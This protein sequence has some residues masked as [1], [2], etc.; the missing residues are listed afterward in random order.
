MK[1]RDT[2][3]YVQLP[4]TL[5]YRLLDFDYPVYIPRQYR[6]FLI[7]RSW[8]AEETDRSFDGPI[9]LWRGFEED[10]LE[11]YKVVS[12]PVVFLDSYSGL[13][14]NP[15]DECPKEKV[16]A[17]GPIGIACP[18]YRPKILGG[19]EY[20]IP[21]VPVMDVVYTSEEGWRFLSPLE[22]GD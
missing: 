8:N 7:D 16:E 4:N 13:W 1:V 5:R 19:Y 10:N 18:L 3:V 9:I 17:F 12:N 2:K 14:A 21:W 6:L 11:H 20:D 15:W 22:W